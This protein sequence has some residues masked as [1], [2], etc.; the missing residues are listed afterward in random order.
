MEYCTFPATI[1]TDRPRE[2][3]ASAFHSP[4]AGEMGQACRHRELWQLHLRLGASLG[5]PKE[6][7]QV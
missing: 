2:L 1:H 5:V 4:Q 3:A 6:I 7:I